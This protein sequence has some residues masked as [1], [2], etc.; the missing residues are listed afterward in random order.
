[1]SNKRRVPAGGDA[2]E[3]HDTIFRVVSAKNILLIYILW[4]MI[5]ASLFLVLKLCIESSI[6]ILFSLPFVSTCFIF[7]FSLRMKSKQIFGVLAVY[8]I[9][10]L[11][12]TIF[13]MSVGLSDGDWWERCFVG[14]VETFHSIITILHSIFQFFISIILIR[15]SFWEMDAS[16]CCCHCCVLCCW[17]C[18]YF[19]ND[20]NE[21]RSHVSKC[22][23]FSE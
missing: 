4:N 16:C 15:M 22:S 10:S 7:I 21:E 8:T 20:E 6:S 23:S 9:I 17:C 12:N 18:P 3:T 2:F 11:L 13:K 5:L 1:M 14:S 19:K